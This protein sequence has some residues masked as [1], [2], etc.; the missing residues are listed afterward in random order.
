RDRSF[1]DDSPDIDELEQMTV[2]DLILKEALRLLAP[3]P[4]VMRKTVRDVAIDG[5]HIPRETLC[6]ITPAVNH[7]DRRIWSDPDRFDPSRFDE[8]RREDQQHRF[9]WVPF[10]GGAHKC[11]GMQFGTLE[12]KAI[13][14]QM[15]RTYTW[16]VP[17]DY[18]VR[19]DNTSLPIPVDGLPVTLR[20]R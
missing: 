2:L 5:Y 12:V 15:L 20:H 3:V 19:W 18:H 4:L 8:P 7:F 1:G 17:N 13:L 6:A 9:A 11:I 14:H 10:G 16:T